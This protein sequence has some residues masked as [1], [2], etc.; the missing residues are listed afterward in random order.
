MPCGGH[1]AAWPGIIDEG[2]SVV[3]DKIKIFAFLMVFLLGMLGS[4]QPA[5]AQIDHSSG[6]TF[7]LGLDLPNT[8]SARLWLN[9]I[10]G[11]GGTLGLSITSGRTSNFSLGG[12]VL[13][14]ILDEVIADLYAKGGL[15]LAS[16]F[17]SQTSSAAFRV[18]GGAGVEMSPLREL[19]SS[20]EAILGTSFGGPAFFLQLQGAIHVYF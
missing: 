14:K 15:Q 12:E 7:G 1:R 10:L 8:L 18:T 5:W 4:A 6:R 2:V 11:L 17:T 20:L 3:S 16:T 9:D 19:A 13:F